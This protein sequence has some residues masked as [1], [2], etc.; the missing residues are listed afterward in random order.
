MTPVS[1]SHGDLALTGHLVDGPPGA[2]GILLVHGGGGID[3]HTFAQAERYAALG[4]TCFALDMFGPTE[5]GMENN[6]AT[7][8]ALRDDVDLLRARAAA[9][10]AVLRESMSSSAPIGAVGFCFGGM[11]VLTMARGGAPLAGV[12]SMHGALATAAPAQPGAVTA[13]V[14]ACHGAIDP[15]VPLSDVTAFI[16]EMDAAG[17][18]AQL[19]SYSAAM[20]GFTHTDA[21]DSAIPGVAY[22][23]P[24]DER[25][26]AA[27]TAFYAEC[28]S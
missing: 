23:R 12:V 10:L 17:V 1:Y 9:G 26:F 7:I 19:I 24:T 5:G 13:K 27:A 28:F 21:V 6:R 8:M 16:E 14:L 25:S 11:T 2:P 18:D 15:H 3:A 4:Y 22:H 20:H